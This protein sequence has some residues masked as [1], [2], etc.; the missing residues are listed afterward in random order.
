MCDNIMPRTL[1]VVS[2]SILSDR[3]DGGDITKIMKC[4]AVFHFVYFLALVRR[5]SHHAAAIF[6]VTIDGDDSMTASIL[7]CAKISATPERWFHV[8]ADFILL[9]AMMLTW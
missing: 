8:A 9:A 4:D 6:A 2:A 1:L 7:V 5:T 3:L